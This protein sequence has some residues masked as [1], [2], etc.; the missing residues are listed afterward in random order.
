MLLLLK[1]SDND[2]GKSINDRLL[3]ASKIINYEFRPTF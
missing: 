3:R 2:L 1:I